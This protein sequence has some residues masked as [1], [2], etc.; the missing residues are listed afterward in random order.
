[1]REGRCHLA[2][3]SK[4]R[5][6]DQ[7]ALEFLQSCLGLLA[8]GQIPD[9]P[10]EEALA[11][12]LHLTHGQFDRKGRPVTALADDYPPLA[13]DPSLTGSIVAIQVTIM[14]AAIGIGHQQ[15]DIPP[16]DF[17]PLP[18]EHPLGCR[19]EIADRS[20]LVDYDHCI[21]Y[22]IEDGLQMRFA[23]R[24]SH[25]RR[26]GF[27]PRVLEPLASHGHGHAD[28]YKCRCCDQAPAL[29]R[30]DNSI[31][32]EA[33]GRACHGGKPT[34]PKAGKRTGDDHA[35]NEE[36]ECCALTEFIGSQEAN[37]DT[38]RYRHQREQQCGR[39]RQAGQESAGEARSPDLR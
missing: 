39:K 23:A 19:T 8:L 31:T 1:M 30:P 3:R 36:N 20:G 27:Y 25:S 12:R 26:F 17:R 21:R 37:R 24:E 29:D 18:S 2:E 22:R 6:V 9:E 10:G 15:A 33:G 16:G 11:F 32:P 7:F 38:R 4:P 5:D 14:R 28:D 34:C 13:D 35:G